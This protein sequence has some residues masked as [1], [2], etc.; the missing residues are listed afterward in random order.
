MEMGIA[1]HGNV[2]NVYCEIKLH[3][4]ENYPFDSPERIDSNRFFSALLQVL[5]NLLTCGSKVGYPSDL[6][7][8]RLHCRLTR[9]HITITRLHRYTILI[10]DQRRQAQQYQC[11]LYH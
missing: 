3:R 10:V 4:I 6:A 11:N 9:L 5:D 1:K 2:T 8:T 7:S